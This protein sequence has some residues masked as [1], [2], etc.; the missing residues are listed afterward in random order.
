MPL[1]TKDLQ[2]RL[3]KRLANYK[4]NDAA[5]KELAERVMVEGMTI[6]RF[7]VCIY[8]ICLDYYSTKPPK[9]DGFYTRAGSGAS[10]FQ[11]FPYGIIDWDYWHVK[12][13]FNVDELAGA[14]GFNR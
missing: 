10:R 5:I 6:T 11:V 9:L 12:A 13:E 8:G 3:S 4:I 7:D 1:T 14:G 2:K